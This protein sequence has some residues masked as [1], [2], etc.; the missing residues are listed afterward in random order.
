MLLFLSVKLSKAGIS[1]SVSKIA[2]SS[3]KLSVKAIGEKILPSTRSN[4]KI[5]KRRR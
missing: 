2:P 5:G 3:A 1:V 4:V